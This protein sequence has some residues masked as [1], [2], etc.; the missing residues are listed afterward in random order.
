M[1]NLDSDRSKIG[2][3]GVAHARFGAPTLPIL[4]KVIDGAASPELV[5]L[6]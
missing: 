1:M 4:R 5:L 2:A 6:A 3:L